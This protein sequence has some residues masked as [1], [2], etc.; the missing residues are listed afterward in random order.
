[1]EDYILKDYETFEEKTNGLLLV[2][3]K[4]N[5]MFIELGNLCYI[6]R[7]RMN[8]IVSN[9][10]SI[11]Y[12][13]SYYSVKDNEKVLDLKIIRTADKCFIMESNEKCSIKIKALYK[14]LNLEDDEKRY[15]D[16]EDVDILLNGEPYFKRKYK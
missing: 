4:S 5:L 13:I 15:L 12:D 8:R 16:E 7:E 11:K 14:V 1:M 10:N 3:K 2:S 9:K 6:T